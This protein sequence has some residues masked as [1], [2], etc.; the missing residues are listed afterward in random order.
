MQ[1]IGRTAVFGA[2]VA[3]AAFGLTACGGDSSAAPATPSRECTADDV[4][5]TGNFGQAPTITIPDDCAPPKKLLT[6][7]LSAGTGKAA[8]AGSKLSMNYLVVT[9]SNKKKL[10]S[11]FDR[12]EPFGL[13]LGAGQVIEG[14]DQGLVG[15]KQG[16]RRLMIIPPAL[17]YKD[18]GRG[19]APNE[20]LVFVTDALSVS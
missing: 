9:W 11:S 5:T 10:D 20:T 12:G 2:V 19:I 4:K 3:V 16:G 18:G 13:D 6:K 15:V 17:A 8:A 7:D 1:N 14:W